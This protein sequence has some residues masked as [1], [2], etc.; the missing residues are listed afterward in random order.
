MKKAMADT[1]YLEVS[2]GWGMTYMLTNGYVRVTSNLTEIPLKWVGRF[3]YVDDMGN[4]FLE[5]GKGRRLQVDINPAIPD[6]YSAR[7]QVFALRREVE[8][9]DKTRTGI[10][11]AH[12]ALEKMLANGSTEA[13]I[14]I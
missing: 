4:V 11:R 10:K 8:D 9:I 5:E 6:I 1:N 2:K 14:A 7:K 3:Y 12:L 13:S